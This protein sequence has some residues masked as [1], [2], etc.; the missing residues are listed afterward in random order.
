MR[1]DV[2]SA[3]NSLY[4]NEINNDTP[5]P[6]RIIPFTTRQVRED[7]SSKLIV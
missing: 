5:Q 6:Q 3:A 7:E 4:P 1:N 2:I